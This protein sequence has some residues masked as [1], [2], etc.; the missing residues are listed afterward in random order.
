VIS[1]YP[2]S[3]FVLQGWWWF[4]MHVYFTPKAAV[5]MIAVMLACFILFALSAFTFAAAAHE[6]NRKTDASGR[7][8]KTVIIDPGHGEPDGGAIGV[9]GVIE[10]NINLSISL[11][12]KS[13]FQIAGFSVIMTRQDDNAIYDKGSNTIRKKKITDLRNRL[14]IINSH[15]NAVLISIH[16]N[17]YSSSQKSGSLVLYSPNNTDSKHLAQSIQSGIQNMLQPQNTREV[18]QAQKNLFLLYHAK[19]PAVMVE[20]GFLSNPDECKLL[21]DDTYQNQMAFSVFCGVLQFY[22]SK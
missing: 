17:I 8:N 13:L 6:S 3:Y 20:C 18:R 1:G 11:K 15:P 16:Q 7:A 4:R 12:L 22:S 2:P 19:S 5:A 9:D 14:A 10:K 21:Q